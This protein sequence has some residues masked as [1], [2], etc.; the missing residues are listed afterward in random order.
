[1]FMKLF[2]ICAFDVIASCGKGFPKKL[3]NLNVRFHK[4]GKRYRT[5]S[6][7]ISAVIRKYRTCHSSC[8]GVSPQMTP[9]TVL[10]VQSR[11]EKQGQSFR[12]GA[13]VISGNHN[14]CDSSGSVKGSGC[15]LYGL[16]FS[17]QN[18]KMSLC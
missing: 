16:S 3:K 14:F 15:N 2:K 18:C 1:M 8:S 11:P 7:T 4:D 13:G 9:Q 10:V 5:I 17:A 12:L 6:D